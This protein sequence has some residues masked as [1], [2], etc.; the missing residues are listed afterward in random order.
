MSLKT[1]AVVYDALPAVL[2]GALPFTTDHGV[3]DVPALSAQSE[4]RVM[5]HLKSP[6][7]DAWSDALSRVG[8]CAR[9]VRLVG[10]SETIDTTTGEIT[11]YS[12][13]DE[14]FGVTYVRCGN[15]RGASVRPARGSMRRTCST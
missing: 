5:E 4:Q 8:N 6:G 15:R 7:F 3:P 1:R 2:P 10:R 9:P 12:S 11:T 14:P 13:A